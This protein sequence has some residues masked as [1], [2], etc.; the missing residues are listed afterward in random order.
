MSA[1]EWVSKRPAV[2]GAG[3]YEITD[4]TGG[5]WRVAGT[6]DRVYDWHPSIEDAKAACEAHRAL[7]SAALIKQMAGALQFI[8]AFYEPGQ[9]YLDTNAWTQAEASGRAA[10]Q[11]V[12]DA[13]YW[14]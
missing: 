4:M 13:G 3:P 2:I 1:L 14:S 6:R 7:G 12:K 11:A 5:V 8:L 9:R 10:M